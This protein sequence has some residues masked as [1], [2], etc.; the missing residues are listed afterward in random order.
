MAGLNVN[1]DCQRKINKVKRKRD[2]KTW[3]IW[4]RER[5]WFV[6]VCNVMTGLNKCNL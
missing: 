4:E 2:K 3:L 5:E 1:P 6:L